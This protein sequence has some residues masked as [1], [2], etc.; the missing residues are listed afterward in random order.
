MLNTNT[1]YC[2]NHPNRKAYRFC[3]AC[4]EFICNYCAFH[5][6]HISHFDKIKSF[7]DLLKTYFPN[8][9]QQNISNLSKYIELFHFILNYNSSF[10]PFDLNEIMDQINEKFDNYINKLVEL[11]MK[12]KILISEKFGI[13]QSTMSEQEKKVIETQNKLLILLND[14]DVNYLEKMNT[15]L[16]Q[17][18]LNKSEKNMIGFIEEYNKLILTSFNDED[19]FDYKYSLYAAQKLIDKSNKFIK[20]NILDKMVTIFFD[21]ALK[22]VENLYDKINSQNNEDIETLKKNFSN[23]QN[24][25]FANN[26]NDEDER[27]YSKKINFANINNMNPNINTNTNNN[28]N[29]NTNSNNNININT[30]NNKNPN[31]NNVLNIINAINNN[32][33]N[34]PKEEKPKINQVNKIKEELEKQIKKDKQNTNTEKKPK[35]ELL[36]IEF[37]PPE[38][39]TCQFTEKELEEMDMDDDYEKEFLKIEE[40]GDDGL[41]LAEIIDGNCSDNA[42]VSLENFFLDNMD[43]KLDIQYYEGIAFEGENGGEGLNDEAIVVEANDEENKEEGKKEEEV[44][45][46]EEIKKEEVKKPENKKMNIVEE[47]KAKFNNRDM[48]MI[49]PQPGTNINTQQ[50]TQTKS[51]KSSA[52]NKKQEKDKNINFAQLIEDKAEQDEPKQTKEKNK[53]NQKDE[54]D[55][56]VSNEEV[57]KKLKELCNLA[58]SGKKNSFEFQ[59]ILKNLPWPTRGKV[60]LIAVNQ[61]NSSLHIYNELTNKV[62]EIKVDFKLAMHLSYINIP[63]YLYIS[64]GKVNGKD[65]TSIKRISRTGQNSVKCEELAQ[66][67]QGRSSHC[68]V[69][70]KSINSLFFIS[71]SRIKSCEKYNLNKNKMEAFPALRVSREKCSACLLNEKYL[72]VFFGF[73]RT[74]NKFETSIEKIYVNDAMSWELI[75][76][77][78]NQ[79]IFKKQSCACIPFDRDGQKGVIITGGI[80]SLRN[81]TKETV[82]INID[83]NKAEIFSP[84]P[85]NSS[86]TNVYFKNFEEYKIG[87]ELVNFS[88]EFNAV[89][90]DLDKFV[91]G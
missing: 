3:D 40:D 55:K 60:E 23:I 13:L 54:E 63:P 75:N 86:F 90:F 45:K 26:E 6:K 57:D 85:M 88:N 68:T 80:N 47:M 83:K 16:E 19:D 71:G 82:Y 78:G 69:H 44:K 84:L 2:K 12:M 27:R 37:D 18:R 49:K 21:E 89:K 62:E 7:K 50:K 59:D 66:L 79:N 8:F 74:K 25:N 11:K 5:A 22:N 4:K 91:F 17:I 10:M 15:C 20:E 52:E 56:N 64:G 77:T 34:A 36:K 46:E 32:T 58:R 65:I 30:N 73:D 41:L 31:T 42:T 24:N 38:I 48:K 67:N 9:Q 70:I 39:E 14:E 72:Y 87:N 43:D 53:I 51:N 35:V 1:I 61:K 29:P 33:A 81:E 76:L 28:T